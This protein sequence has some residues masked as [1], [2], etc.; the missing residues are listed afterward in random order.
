MRLFTMVIVQYLRD[1]LFPQ[2]R[3]SRRR[4]RVRPLQHQQLE[5][6]RVLTLPATQAFAEGDA[7]VYN[8]PT[9]DLVNDS[10][11]FDAFIDFA[12][13]IDSYF[14]AP[15]FTGTYTIDVGDFGNTVDPEVAVYIASTG[16]RVGYNDD[17]SAVN[18]DARLTLNLTADTRYIIAVGDQPATTA[19]NVSIIVTAPFRTGSFL[20][21]PDVFG[22][23]STSVTLD[24]PTD[25]D[26]YSIT[27]P[28]D[29]TG[30]LSVTTSASTFSHR[31]ALFDA[32]GTLIQGPLVSI[33]IANVAPNAE[34][35]IAVF[36][37]NYSTSGS[38]SLNIDFAEQ[39]ALVT[40]TADSGPGS[41]RQA[42]LD[43][44]A[45]PNVGGL[46]D[47]INFNIPGAGPFNIVLATELPLITDAVAINGGTQPGTV[48][49]PT[50][51]ID[52][53]ALTG[54]IDG[55]T[56]DAA[57]TA[58][59]FLNVRNFPGDGIEVHARLVVLENNTIGTDWGGVSSLA[60]KGFGVRIQDGAG[61]RIDS[62]VISANTL[63][64]ITIVGDTAD[65][66]VVIGNT[67]GARFGGEVALPNAGN[68][69]VVTDGDTTVVSNNVISGNTLS[70]IV[71]SGSS[72]ANV[73]TGNAVGINLS[74][75]AA[76][77]NGDQGILIQSSGN[78]IGGNQAAL[79]NVISGNG[80]TG[81]TITGVA[82]TGNVIEGNLIGTNTA[83]SAAVPNTSDGVR[84][85]NAPNN[86]IGSDADAAAR[87]VIS[88][89]GAFGVSFVQP[90][91]SGGL[92]VGN[93]IGV[94]SNGTS[95]LGNANNGVTLS[96]GAT[97]VQI[98][99][100]VALAQ[101]IISANK[102]NGVAILTN[103]DNNRISR[104]RIGTTVSGAPLGNIVAGI[105]ILSA[106]NTIGGANASFAN[107]IAGNAQGITLK[108]ET[109]RGNE[110]LF[111]TI[112]TDTASNVGAGIQF[113][114]GAS[115]NTVGPS[116][117]IRRNET[118]IRVNEGSVENKIT[119]N[120]IGENINLGID[121]F[122]SEGATANDGTDADNGGNLLQN[123][124]VISG[125]PRLVGAE[126]EI[127]FSINGSPENSAY[128]LTIEFFI[129]DGGSEGAQFLGSTTYTAADLVAG[130]KTVSFVGTSGIAAG[131]SKIV[132]TATD[133]FGNTSEFS[134]QKTV[135]AGG[136]VSNV[137]VDNGTPGYSETAGTWNTSGLFGFN[138]SST[139]F[140]NSANA[141]ATW[142]PNLQPGFYSVSIFKLAS[143]SSA[144]G[145][146]LTVV[147][148]GLSETQTVDLRAASAGFVQLPGVFYFKGSPE[149]LVRL[150]QGNTVQILRTDAIRFTQVPAPSVTVDNGTP[151][152]VE[153][154]GTWSD[155]GLTGFN[156]TN[157]RISSAASAVATWTPALSAGYY[158]ISIF[159]PATTASSAGARISVLA[160]GTSYNHTVDLRSA[161]GGFIDL[162]GKFFFG[163]NGAE[164]VR[165]Q[166]GTTLGNLRADAIR[167]T[168][169][170]TP[171]IQLI[172]NGTPGYAE[173]GAW[174]ASSLTGVNGTN[175]RFSAAAN[176]T[177]TWTPAGL[178]AGS[179]R[180]EFFKVANAASSVGVTITI[181]HN[182]VSEN[183]TIDLSTGTSG[184]VDLGVLTFSG[185]PGEFIRLS[186]GAVFGTLRADAVR[187]TK[188]A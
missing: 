90:G 128:P 110:I 91:V 108:G 124:P 11:S 27:A 113:V 118:G 63:G 51:A 37:N 61:N 83:G 106:D 136:V 66:N 87:N 99:G 12:G 22:D 1:T 167:F 107:I 15:Q 92:V 95:A 14:F 60:N 123:F 175:T 162:P 182:G 24:V 35:R 184:F 105:A 179:Y 188:V 9:V 52:G 47:P 38:L 36:P 149:E 42:I 133:L 166:Q 98:G 44:N 138:N 62:N 150:T 170:S 96:S 156:N 115:R 97:N 21:T 31:L 43:A 168:K 183:R 29:A 54:T 3:R 4:Q 160:N 82:A 159:L 75:N 67:I 109:A 144:S 155:S 131:T 59:R 186:Q 85:V 7:V 180:V 154:A 16:A 101:N 145:A 104:N 165:M 71:L 78:Q 65:D 23:A 10:L 137:V 116:N 176:A 20:L 25:I 181:S 86:R 122:P 121:L 178:T 39:G 147:H 130:V 141:A 142:T 100:S 139:R 46:A 103:S 69:L 146:R 125:S 58:I 73:V 6:R 84:V 28:P 74:G 30:G 76:L 143:Q 5:T 134:T 18:D 163:G 126:L 50:V 45:H 80:K 32:A 185:S 72:T 26:Y 70:G 64:G 48:A 161:S 57:D 132:G 172:D 127:G 117:T 49:T 94:A 158:S 148:D 114:S 135:V 33:N 177:A 41:L 157:T 40:N 187:L 88:G 102:G 171:T 164:L 56:V 17:L 2:T 174:S 81:I 151:G 8:G 129:S 93:L 119:R 173:V 19:G 111:N 34:Y 169:T 140:S 112:G 77:P 13:D 68:G 89:N 53:A 120:K 55:L 153:T 152:Y 79:Q